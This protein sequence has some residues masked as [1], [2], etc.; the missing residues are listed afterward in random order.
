M[1]VE[2]GDLKGMSPK[3]VVEL[4]KAG[5]L[6][7]ILNPQTE[8][9]AVEEPAEEPEEAVVRGSADL[10]AHTPDPR[11]GQLAREAL[12]SMTSAEIVQ[13]QNDGRL[14]DLL[15]RKA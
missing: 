3:R 10:G 11:S 13:A 2:R 4:H 8:Q 7:H 15:G 1:T 9:T 12:R 5:E 6:D 14:D